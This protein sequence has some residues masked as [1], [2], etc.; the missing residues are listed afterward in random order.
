MNGIFYVL[1]SGCSWRNL[2]K[3]LP[4]WQTVYFYFRKWRMNGT[5]ESIHQELREKERVH[6]GRQA[7][8]R[9]AV[10]DSQSVKTSEK[11]GQ[12]VRRQQETDRTQAAYSGRRIWSAAQGGGACR[13]PQ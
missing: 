12:R 9:A 6:I 7:T 4:P 13:E 10:M 2:P 3:D 8:P 11:G 1:R 5:W